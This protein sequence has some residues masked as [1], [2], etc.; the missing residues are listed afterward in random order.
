MVRFGT[1]DNDAPWF[2]RRMA[3]LYDQI[4]GKTQTAQTL[5]VIN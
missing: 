1:L 2:S 5:A 4:S 3:R